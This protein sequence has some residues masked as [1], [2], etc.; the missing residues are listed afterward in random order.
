MIMAKDYRDSHLAP[1]KGASYHSAFTDNPH[2]SLVWELEKKALDNIVKR[3]HAD[4]PVE[5]LDFACGTGRILQHLAGRAKVSVGVDLSPSMLDVARTTVPSAELIEAD[6]T[7]SDVLGDRKF[8]LITAFRFFP[9]AQVEL[10]MEAMH[11][12]VR[13]LAAGGHI[14]FNNH[15]NRSSLLYRL[16]RL[17]RRSTNEGMSGQE[18]NE[19]VAAAGLRIEKTYHIGLMPAT[20]THLLLPRLLLGMVERAAFRM[21]CMTGLS[22][23]LVFVCGRAEE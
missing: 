6:I 5:H 7:R 11:S 9:N 19:I 8:N 1:D 12:L 14:V 23:D 4:R 18:V 15:M 17:L 13:H 21:P 22:Q 16:A 10:R 3:F 20:E 2:R